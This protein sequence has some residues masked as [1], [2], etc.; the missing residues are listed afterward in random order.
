MTLAGVHMLQDM[1]LA[2]VHI[3]YEMTLA[4]YHILSNTDIGLSLAS[5]AAGDILV[6][7]W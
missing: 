5:A 1:T 3:L 4:N 6:W 7:K 2:G